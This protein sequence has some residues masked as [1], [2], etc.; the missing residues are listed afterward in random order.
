[1]AGT[2]L[3]AGASGVIGRGAVAHFAEQGRPVIAVSRRPPPPAPGVTHL[4]LDL[5]DAAATAEALAGRPVA[6]VVYAALHEKADLV[7]GWRDPEQMATNLAMLRNLVEPLGDALEHVTLFQGTKAYGVHIRP[8]PVPAKESWPRH[9]HDN[10]Y[11]LQEDWLAEHAA[12]RGFATTIFRPQVVFGDAIGVSMNLT[13]VIG[14]LAALAR[15]EGRGFAFPGGP[16]YVLEAVDAGLIARA[17]DWA[18]SSPAAKGRTFNITNGDVMVWQNLWPA[19]ADA[20]GVEPAPPEP[21]RL[22]ETLP[23]AAEAWA[24]IAR[25]HAL[26]EPDLARILG[27]SHHYAD[28]CFAHGAERPPAP[29]LVSTIALRQAGFHDCIDTEAMFRAQFARLQAARVL[30]PRD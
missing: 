23:A 2:V 19:F 5:T 26:A 10:F 12:K 29:V 17:A 21:V 1:M 9:P 18:G 25:R 20:L 11:W 22:A 24:A 27:Q 28:F 6:R 8:F 16:P 14:V 3:V 15:A 13:P 7:A 4:P 30:P